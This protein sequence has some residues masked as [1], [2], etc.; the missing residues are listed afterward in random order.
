MSQA[1]IL[2]FTSSL[3][4]GGTEKEVLL[5]STNIN[6]NKFLPYVASLNGKGPIA[7]SL[8][9]FS[10]PVFDLEFT[11]FRHI[12]GLLR[13]VWHLIQIV[14]AHN[15][16]IIQAYSFAPTVFGAVVSVFTGAR[17]ISF[18]RSLH[19]WQNKRYRWVYRLALRAADR[20]LSN[21]EAGKNTILKEAGS[22]KKTVQVIYNQVEV[23]V[24][25]PELRHRLR[26]ELGIS[27]GEIVVGMVANLRPVKNPGLFV[28]VALEV[29][30]LLDGVSFLSIGDGPERPALE[31]R[32]ARAGMDKRI[33][34]LGSIVP[35][36]PYYECM[37][38]F[39]LTSN[40][41]GCPMAVLEAMSH[42]LPIVATRVGGV[43]EV[44][45]GGKNGYLVPAGDRHL[46][47]KTL[48]NLVQDAG[49]REQMGQISR[50][51]INERFDLTEILG[52]LERVYLEL[53]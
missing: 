38:I 7:D 15:I 1:G 37:D 13:I 20:I 8:R 53:L 33:R 31:T 29:C 12:P 44:V 11:G 2:L 26:K 18:Q 24:S 25:D 5:L 19:M 35:A 45:E 41:E 4:L 39:M 14:R 21:S 6:R 47:V 40:S 22:L 42:G 52:Q 17:L 27:S 43:P 10:V 48:Y 3:K 28:D 51:I 16:Q 23:T 9:Q 32:V 30:A 34:F 50:Q 46:L 36:D 49:L